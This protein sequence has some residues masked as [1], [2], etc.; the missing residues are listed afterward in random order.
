M[1]RLVLFAAE[2]R[3]R[4]AVAAGLLLVLSN[5]P[6]L[7]FAKRVLGREGHWNDLA[8]WPAFV[9]VAAAGVVLGWSTLRNGGVAGAAEPVTVS[10]GITARLRRR[11]RSP[12]R[13]GAGGIESTGLTARLAL[14]R[15][16]LRLGVAL[17]AGYSVWAVLS[18]AWSVYPSATLW[19]SVTYLGLAMLAV[20][21]AAFSDEEL[22]ETVALLAAAAVS[23]SLVLAVVWPDA[24]FD[25]N[26]DL[27]GVYTNRNSLGPLA[28]LGVIAGMRWALIPP[29]QERH[30]VGRADSTGQERRA[31]GSAD[32]TTGMAG[33]WRIP[34][35]RAAVT[36]AGL[37]TANGTARRWRTPAAR[38]L[39]AA[40]VVSLA[41]AGSRTALIALVTAV[42]AASALAGLARLRERLTLPQ[43]AGAVFASAIAVL[44]AGA[45][46]LAALWDSPTF[47][48]R[49]NIWSLVW[50]RVAERP[51]TGH[52]FFA[53]W[54]V[55]SLVADDVLLQRGSAHNSAVET[56]LGLGAVGLVPIVLL[57]VLALTNAGVALWRRP[58]GDTWMW[59][60]VVVLVVV[61]NSTESFVLWFSYIW[62]LLLTAALRRSGA[63]ARS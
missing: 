31:V 23:A 41:V 17:A 51:W 46:V 16:V 11:E 8:V 10:T 26:D 40:S 4:A 37:S 5:G 38:A 43:L 57:A 25:H 21:L 7:L 54:E 2:H 22:A 9:A 52:G 32:S 47:E 12:R 56:A 60:A 15:V 58:C 14:P 24:A 62:V 36:A 59:A 13:G 45:A 48:Q 3:W 1:K 50:D 19:R 20:A 27:I 33:R 49:R 63:E 34:V 39:L 6:V 35:H 42:V 29:G 61:E 55:P 53:F 44:G 30:A 28:A 18:S